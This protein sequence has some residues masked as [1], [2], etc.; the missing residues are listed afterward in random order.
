VHPII[1]AS[2]SKSL[3][4]MGSSILKRTLSF[5]RWKQEPDIQNRKVQ[6]IKEQLLC[7][8]ECMLVH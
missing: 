2:S 1:L 6:W 4:K 8:Y 5:T 7:S 3:S